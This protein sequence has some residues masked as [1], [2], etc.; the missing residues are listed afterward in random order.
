MKVKDLFASKKPAI[1]F[2]FF[3]PKTDEGLANLMASIASLKE[4]SPSYVTMTYGAGGSTRQKT[5]QLVS[6]I[7]KETGMEAAAHLTCVGHS[8]KELNDVL[9][10]LKAHGIENLIALRGD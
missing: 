7:K 4:L 2:E 8:R 10:E 5:V 9:S 6:A 3:P 1:S